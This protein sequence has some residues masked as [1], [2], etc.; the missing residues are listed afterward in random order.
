MSTLDWMGKAACATSTR[1]P[2]TAEPGT[3]PTILVA[4]MADMCGSCPVLLD[5][6]G[7]ATTEATAGFWA[8]S[9][10]THSDHTAQ[11]CLPFGDADEPADADE[12]AA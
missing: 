7:Y 10:R 5:C 6:A 9:W 8:G 1:L 12:V 4:V 3:C 11:D 2:W